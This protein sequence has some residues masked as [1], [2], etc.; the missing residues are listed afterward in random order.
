MDGEAII[1]V[2]MGAVLAAFSLVMVGYSFFRREGSAALSPEA[3][4]AAEGEGLDAFPGARVG[5][6]SILDSIETLEL[7]YQLGNIPDGQY[8]EQLQAYRLEAAAAIKSQLDSG[9][10]SLELMLE[11][12]VIGAR[13]G[14]SEATPSGEWGS[15]TRCD[16]PVPL[17]EAPCPH[18]GAP[19]GAARLSADTGPALS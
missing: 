7:D 9:E 14:L 5:L 1:A 12:E 4:G 18:C 10:A 15:C 13:A 3:T 6:D 8:R 19:V 17:S 2:I 11:L 16:A